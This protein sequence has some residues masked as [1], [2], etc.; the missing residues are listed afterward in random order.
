MKWRSLMAILSL[1][2]K[3]ERFFD[4]TRSYK[5]LLGKAKKP[6]KMD[7]D[8]WED[9]DAKV[10]SLIHLNFSNEVIHNVIDEEKA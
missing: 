8:E 3:D 4:L 1:T 10:A 6:Q 7:D 5:A 2:K 9:M